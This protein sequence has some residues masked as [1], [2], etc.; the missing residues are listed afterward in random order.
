MVARL[1]IEL[2]RLGY[3]KNDFEIL[4]RLNE[5]AKVKINTPYAVFEIMN[6]YLAGYSPGKR[7]EPLN[8]NKKSRNQLWIWGTL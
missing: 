1:Q 6:L 2:A 5:T 8:Q 3:N 7:E 4:Y